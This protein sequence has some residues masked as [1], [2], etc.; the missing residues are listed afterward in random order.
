MVE[1]SRPSAT[2]L[3]YTCECKARWSPN[4]E[5][6]SENALLFLDSG[7][8]GGVLSRGWVSNAKLPC[9]HRKTPTPISDPSGNHI[10]GSGLHYTKTVDM[11]ME[12]HTNKIRFELGDMPPGHLDGYLP[13]AWLKD[14]NP[15]IN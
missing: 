6:Q 12:H 8:M 10:S 3:V 14:H 2:Y 9:I 1:T 15:D 13:M 4:G 7:A 5:R 11:S